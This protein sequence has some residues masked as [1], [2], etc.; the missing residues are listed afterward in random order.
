MAKLRRDL[1]G[2]VFNALTV[3]ELAGR[4]N[5]K[6]KWKCLCKCGKETVADGYQISRGITT[7]CGCR[8]FETKNARHGQ[9]K[10][11]AHA[12]WRK[13]LGRCMNPNDAAFSDYGGRGITVCERWTVF[14]NFLED[15]GHPADGLSIDRIDNNSG[16]DPENCR[17]ASN[18]EQ[19]N[20]KRNNH[21][22]I[23]NGERKT[24]SEWSRVLG[25]GIGTIERRIAAGWPEDRLLIP[26][27]INR[28]I[29]APA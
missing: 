2:L 22:V 15:M 3:I 19:A 5:G 16:Y 11:R 6:A 7:S 9:S 10:T 1:S 17:W 18:V 12:I 14:E 4:V 25:I 28:K 26:P 20:N 29:R 8:K 24:I 23:L 27:I 13:M 21:F